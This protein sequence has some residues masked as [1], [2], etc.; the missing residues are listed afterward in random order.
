MPAWASRCKKGKKAHLQAR[1]E[2]VP[3]VRDGARACATRAR[4][5]DENQGG[6][7]LPRVT[8][9]SLLQRAQPAGLADAA[10]RAQARASGRD[11]RGRLPGAGAGRDRRAAGERPRPRPDPARRD[12][13]DRADERL[14]GAAADPA[15]RVP[16][17][18]VLPD[19][20]RQAPARRRRARGTA[21]AKFKQLRGHRL[22][23][24]PLPARRLAAAGGAAPGGGRDH[25][26]VALAA[27]PG[28]RP[29]GAGAA[30][31]RAGCRSTTP[32]S[33]S[34]PT[35]RTASSAC[36]WRSSRSYINQSDWMAYARLAG[37]G[38]VAVQA[39]RRGVAGELPV[40]PAVPRRAREAGLRRV[41]AADLGQR[42]RLAAAR[43]RPGAPGRRTR[44]RRSCR[45]SMRPPQ[46]RARSRPSRR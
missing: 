15:G 45:S 31:S 32:S 42:A 5:A 35:R 2:G 33:A 38:G 1:S 23:P 24:P 8:R 10:V 4:Y 40:R 21:A 27:A 41:P 39:D 29:G 28:A 12:V 34:R 37:A 30:G 6:G 36:A 16:A 43:L 46:G 9:W 20:E 14:A 13:A 7:V 17:Q 22:R 11:R 19:A 3:G 18:A 26:L 44:R 25:D